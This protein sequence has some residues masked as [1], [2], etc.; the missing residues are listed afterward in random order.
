MSLT[1]ACKGN[2]LDAADDQLFTEL[3]T[4]DPSSAPD[5]AA[6]TAAAVEETPPVAQSAAEQVPVSAP[7]TPPVAVAEPPVE[8][9]VTTVDPVDPS[10]IEDGKTMRLFREALTK[11]AE[12][13][14]QQEFTQSIQQGAEELTGGD[15]E[16]RMKLNDLISRAV[17]PAQRYAAEQAALANQTAKQTSA[18]WIAAQAVLPKEQLDAVKQQ[19]QQLL[20]LEGPE[21]ME[22]VAFGQRDAMAAHTQALAQRDQR[23]AELELQI[24]AGA[25]LQERGVADVVDGGP[26]MNGAS[27]AQRIDSARTDDELFGA[28]WSA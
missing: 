7:V 18:L 1:N 3:F 23:I 5:E 28:L 17:T 11:A 19:F 2:L 21:V 27:R 12:Q 4:G 10:L 16:Q 26:S 20:S 8:T 13:R 14:K 25:Q 15:A 6:T 9:T 24:A 22:R